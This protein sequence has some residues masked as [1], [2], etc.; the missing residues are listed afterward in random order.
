MDGSARAAAVEARDI[1][2][3][4]LQ[5]RIFDAAFFDSALFR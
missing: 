4:F 1:F 3:A 5:G 2:D